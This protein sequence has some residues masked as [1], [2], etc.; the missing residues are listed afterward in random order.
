[1]LAES[2]DTLIIR[3]GGCKE[4]F[5]KYDDA[6]GEGF[7]A[8]T[9]RERGAYPPGYVM[10]EQQSPREKAPPNTSLYLCS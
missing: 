8:R 1:M 4:S 7:F 3:S 9:R 10:S 2:D 5:L 6:G